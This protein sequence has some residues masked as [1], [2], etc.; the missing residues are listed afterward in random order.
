MVNQNPNEMFQG[1]VSS[2]MFAGGGALMVV[3]CIIVMWAEHIGATL[4]ILGFVPFVVS[5]FISLLI[6]NKT[7]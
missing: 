1:K 6:E 4:V 3:G 7:K 2:S 5:G